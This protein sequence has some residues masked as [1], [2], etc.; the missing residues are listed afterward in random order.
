MTGDTGENL[1]GE[2]SR[3]RVRTRVV[4]Q[5]DTIRVTGD[6]LRS[7]LRD[8]ERRFLAS[9]AST[10]TGGSPDAMSEHLA[11]MAELGVIDQHLDEEAGRR[12][13]PYL[14]DRRIGALREY[15]HW[16]ARRVSS[17]FLLVLKVRLERELKRVIG[18]EAY[19]MFLRFEEVEDAAREIET[20]PDSDLMAKVREGTLFRAVLEQVQ[21]G[22]LLIGPRYF[23]VAP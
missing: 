3:V 21:L 10:A 2:Q 22:D 7:A 14:A 9:Q 19:Q 15:C 20:L 13:V 11:L 23:S 4:R 8:V 1:P 6:P 18:P 16:L 12:D 5:G 17:E